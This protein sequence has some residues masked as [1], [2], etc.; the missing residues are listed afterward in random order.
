M[1]ADNPS[2]FPTPTNPAYVLSEGMTLR[3]WLA[4]QALIARGY[5]VPHS[6]AGYPLSNPEKHRAE[7]AYKEAD[8][9]LAAR[10]GGAQ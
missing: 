4:G 7:W 2:A 8:A 6:S 10:K 9:M 5:W 1:S 3:D